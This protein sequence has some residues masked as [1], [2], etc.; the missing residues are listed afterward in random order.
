MGGPRG[1]GNSNSDGEVRGR[2]K[3]VVIEEEEEEEHFMCIVALRVC[4]VV[5][6]GCMMIISFLYT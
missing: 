4:K 3:G 1:E 2:V 6:Q 5:G